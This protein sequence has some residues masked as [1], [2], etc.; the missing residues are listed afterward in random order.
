MVAF[1]GEEAVRWTGWQALRQAW[2]RLA[3]AFGPGMSG[4]MKWMIAV[5]L[6]RVY[7]TDSKLRSGFLRL[8]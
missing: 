6:P 3:R 7:E 4:P 8:S 5:R 2:R 1:M